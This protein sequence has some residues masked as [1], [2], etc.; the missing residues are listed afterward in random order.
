M[1]GDLVCVQNS[2]ISWFT[3]EL[4]SI[5][6]CIIEFAKS[7]DGFRRLSQNDQ[8]VLLKR[9]TFELAVIA[10]AQHY[11][12]ERHT[13]SVNNL[14]LPITLFQCQDQS[15]TAFAREVISCLHILASFRLATTETA[16]FS[17]FVLLE[18]SDSEHLFVNQLKNCLAA[19]LSPRFN[20]ADDVLHRLL[21][22]L[23]R[24]RDLSRLHVACLARFRHSVSDASTIE[25]PPLYSELF[26]TEL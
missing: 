2:V 13:L 24:L 16:L 1:V 6:R 8:I 15:E 7:V 18:T 20:D 21:G 3:S 12:P 9:S 14:V 17:A 10:M 4:T 22:I 19:Q 5:I 25:L 26:S 11:D 23:P